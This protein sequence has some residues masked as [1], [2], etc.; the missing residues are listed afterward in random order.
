M[1]KCHNYQV[2]LRKLEISDQ[3]QAIAAHN[4]L[5]REKWEFLLNYK[6]EM[7]W[8]EYLTFLDFESQGL[9]F[10]EGRVPA[11]FLVA[12]ENGILVGRASIRHQLNEFLFNIGG[13]IGYGV[14]PDYRGKGY[15]KEILKQSLDYLCRL[16][17]TKALITCGDANI[18]SMKVIESQGGVLENKVTFEGALKRRYWIEISEN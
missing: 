3:L 2:F 4:E 8:A 18:A 12:E 17:V 9:N 5:A 6:P 1:A 7:D 14:R 13:H 11:T 10:P 16:G 15:A